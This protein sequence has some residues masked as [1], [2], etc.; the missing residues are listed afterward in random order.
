MKTR[1]LPKGIAGEYGLA[2]KMSK[3]FRMF[4]GGVAHEDAI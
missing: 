2:F 4:L 3:C 1:T